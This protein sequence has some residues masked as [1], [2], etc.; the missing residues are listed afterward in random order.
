MF[1]DYDHILDWWIYEKDYGR[2]KDIKIWD[3]ERNEIDL[4][5]SEKLYDY[6]VKEMGRK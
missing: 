5:T 2:R 6:L 3:G 4:S 1:N